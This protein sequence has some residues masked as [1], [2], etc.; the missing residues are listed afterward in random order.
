MLSERLF[1]LFCPTTIQEIQDEMRQCG[2]DS[3]ASSRVRRPRPIALSCPDL[4]RPSAA[5]NGYATEESAC[6]RLSQRC[7]HVMLVEQGPEW[8]NWQTRW[9]QN[10][11]VLS[12]VWVRPPPP[13][14]T[15]PRINIAYFASEKS[16][17]PLVARRF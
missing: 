8:R 9:T 1:F 6:G 17:S 5:R 15:F 10:P 16:V 13:G 14:P 11:V 2:R 3:G 12:T 4:R 7:A